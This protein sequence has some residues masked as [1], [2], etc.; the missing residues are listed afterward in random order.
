MTVRIVRSGLRPDD[1]VYVP[2][3]SAASA[4][5]ERGTQ[6]LF[7]YT[8]PE[9]VPGGVSKRIRADVFAA[10]VEAYDEVKIDQ[11]ADGSFGARTSRQH[12][13]AP[14]LVLWFD[15][16]VPDAADTARARLIGSPPGQSTHSPR[17]ERVLADVTASH[18]GHAFSARWPDSAGR[19]GEGPLAWLAAV[20][21]G[22]VEA[23]AV[24]LTAE[25]GKTP[26]PP[27][28]VGARNDFP[29]TTRRRMAFA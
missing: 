10:S 11:A 12:H 6:V 19:D 5:G 1:P 26:H 29:W 27:V 16:W 9:L 15:E 4:Q 20:P 3:G 17:T 25:F 28:L 8:R 24:D 23:L 21:A 2:G 22:E 7:V 14:G 18:G 13:D